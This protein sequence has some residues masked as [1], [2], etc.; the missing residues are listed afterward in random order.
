MPL[1][2]EA[3][4]VGLRRIKATLAEAEAHGESLTSVKEVELGVLV[5]WT[6]EM[7]DIP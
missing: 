5:G 2:P 7:E 4:A 1:I 6:S 3:Y